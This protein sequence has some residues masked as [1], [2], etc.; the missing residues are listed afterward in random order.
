MTN[1]TDKPP[2]AN[3]ISM[4]RIGGAPTL[5]GRAAI[6]RAALA[7]GKSAAEIYSPGKGVDFYAYLDANGAFQSVFVAPTDWGDG[8]QTYNLNAA[9]VM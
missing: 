1:P 5:G 7:Q 2:K 9:G 6:V 8:S 4:Q 3:P